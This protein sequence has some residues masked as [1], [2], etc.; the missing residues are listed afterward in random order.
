MKHTQHLLSEACSQWPRLELS[1]TPC[2]KTGWS[3]RRA[4]GC[5][6]AARAPVPSRCSR[7][8]RPTACERRGRSSTCRAGMGRVGRWGVGWR[9]CPSWRTARAPVGPPISALR[10]FEGPPL[11]ALR[12]FDG[13]IY[14]DI[15]QPAAAMPPRQHEVGPAVLLLPLSAC[16]ECSVQA[17]CEV[18]GAGWGGQGARCGGAA[19][20]RACR[21]SQG[22]TRRPCLPSDGRAGRG[23]TAR[24]PRQSASVGHAACPCPCT[25]L[26]R[27][28]CAGQR[29]AGPA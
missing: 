23:W 27:R 14:L 7:R 21:S 19:H 25:A 15:S 13:P 24:A 17:H 5:R 20:V 16:T 10:L 18:P 28:R 8:G 29:G 11:S 9:A 26:A 2:G 3:C 6:R 22:W 12:L 4:C 1:A